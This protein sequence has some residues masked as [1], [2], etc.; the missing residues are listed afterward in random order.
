MIEKSHKILLG[1]GRLKVQQIAEMLGISKKRLHLIVTQ[2]LSMKKPFARWL[3]RF[4][5]EDQ[6]IVRA[7]HSC[8]F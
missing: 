4:L 6:K 1:D 2:K 8:T 3:P 7:I 5:S